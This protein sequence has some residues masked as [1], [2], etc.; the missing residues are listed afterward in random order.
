MLF[1]QLF[2][3]LRSTYSQRRRIVIAFRSHVRSSNT[4]KWRITWGTYRKVN[5]R[6]ESLKRLQGY[7][8]ITSVSIRRLPALGDDI[9]IG[10][11]WSS[12]CS[13]SAGTVPRPATL[14]LASTFSSA[15]HA[16]TRGSAEPERRSVLPREDPLGSAF[17]QTS[18]FSFL[19]VYAQG[20]SATSPW[21]VFQHCS[22][23]HFCPQR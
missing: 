21:S 5:R 8:L 9:V 6:G 20:R 16:T 4:Q 2:N 14:L 18:F 19:H 7:S 22:N 15:T 10:A 3:T 1:V 11:A 12:R 17:T 13:S 23:A